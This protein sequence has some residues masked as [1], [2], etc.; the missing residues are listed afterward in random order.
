MVKKIRKSVPQKTKRLL[1]R[2]INS[3]CPI[4]ENQ[5]VDHFEI[6]HIDENP[7]NNEFSN[8]L[9]L[10]PTCHSKITKG[11]INN[12]HVKFIKEGLKNTKQK[13]EFVSILVNQEICSW[14]QNSDN[15]YAYHLTENENLSKLL[16]LKWNFINHLQKT[17]VLVNVNYEARSLPSGISGIPRPSVLKSIIKYPIPIECNNGLKRL[18]LQEPIQIP[19]KQ[20]F[21][22]E[23]ELFY[24][25]MENQKYPFKNRLYID[26][27][28]DFSD[29][30]KVSVPRIFLNCNSEDEK[31]KIYTIR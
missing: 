25:G 6:H 26:F 12:N 17:V 9:M 21:Q 28:F 18:S 8:L 23:T 2:E 22:F 10:C 7:S 3:V 29:G 5:D 15:I 4:C 16:V 11:D 30:Q 24:F 14:E 19:G 20:A 13:I 1:Q 27:T 31:M